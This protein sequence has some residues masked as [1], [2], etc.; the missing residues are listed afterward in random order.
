MLNNCVF[1]TYRACATRNYSPEI[2]EGTSGHGVSRCRRGWRLKFLAR[3]S[4]RA[5]LW[6]RS[7]R[8][9]SA[10]C[11]SGRG[12]DK[13]NGPGVNKW[14]RTQNSLASENSA[15]CEYNHNLREGLKRRMVGREDLNLRP[16]GP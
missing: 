11:R 9:N 3:R 1:G 13:K 16:P 7:T 8:S 4:L 2:P 10:I 12:S 5:G 15:H 14:P 6:V